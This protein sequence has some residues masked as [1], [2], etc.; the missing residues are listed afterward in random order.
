MGGDGD[1]TAPFLD[2]ALKNGRTL[3]PIVH[4][5]PVLMT[6]I[7]ILNN[8]ELHQSTYLPLTQVKWG[9]DEQKA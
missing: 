6:K 7:V 9:T 3:E 8:Q 4:L 5:S 1:E 2:K